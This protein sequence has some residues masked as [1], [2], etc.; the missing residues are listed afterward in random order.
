MSETMDPHGRS[1]AEIEADVERTRARVTETI[2][3]LRGSISPG[4]VMDQVVDYARGSGGADFMRNLGVSVRDN[5]LPVLLIGSGI[6]WLLMAGQK[7]K[8][9]AIRP[10]ESFAALPLPASSLNDAGIAARASNAAHGIGAAASDAASTVGDT[11]RS[12]AASIKETAGSVVGSA[13]SGASA[14][15]DRI[16]SAASSARAYRHDATDAA[17]AAIDA[18]KHGAHQGGAKLQ[19]GWSRLS[20]EQP[21]L[22]GALGLAAGAALAALLPRTRTE[23]RLMGE[24]SD[25]V[26]GQ[27]VDVAKEQYATVKD[28]VTPHVQGA[29]DAVMQAPEAAQQKMNEDGISATSARDAVTETVSRVAGATSGAAHDLADTSKSSLERL[30]K[31]QTSST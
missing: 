15:G 4:Q 5:P 28:S 24:A 3:A 17:A 29:R 7:N 9:Y 27:A 18:A 13:S 10:R 26:K 2:D 12:A 14:A 11:L 23:D 1:A 8:D 25:A 19:N 6:G 16:G 21:L 22:L 31:D 30:D 20:H